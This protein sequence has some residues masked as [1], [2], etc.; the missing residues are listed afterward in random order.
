MYLFLKAFLIISKDNK[1]KL[2]LKN[3]NIFKDMISQNSE[4]NQNIKVT[5][6]T[7]CYF[8]ESKVN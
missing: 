1:K 2:N 7:Y 3:L 6:F 4:D 8:N 5:M